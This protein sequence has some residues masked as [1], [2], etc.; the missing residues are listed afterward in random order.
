MHTNEIVGMVEIVRVTG[1]LISSPLQ[2]RVREGPC[3][4]GQ[5]QEVQWE[6]SNMGRSHLK[7]ASDLL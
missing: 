6:I 4:G 7:E 5:V 1:G 2:G 3:Y